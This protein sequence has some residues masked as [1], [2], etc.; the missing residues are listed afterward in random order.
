M[1]ASQEEILSRLAEL[2]RPVSESVPAPSYAASDDLAEFERDLLEVHFKP[3]LQRL[4][5]IGQKLNDIPREPVPEAGPGVL[6]ILDR[7]DVRA[8][9]LEAK[10]SK[11]TD[12]GSGRNVLELSTRLE[13]TLEDSY[14]ELAGLKSVA[15]G[16]QESR[17][18]DALKMDSAIAALDAKLEG[19][20]SISTGLQQQLESVALD[21]Q[22]INLQY[23]SLAEGVAKV[24]EQ[25][26]D[27]SMQ[28]S[29]LGETVVSLHSECE[30]MRNEMS[31]FHDKLLPQEH[32]A[33]HT[34]LEE[35]VQ[36]IRENFDELLR[37]IA[38]LGH[39]SS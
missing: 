24:R 8:T 1:Q 19:N 29:L 20:K 22:R 3:L 35:K 18:D 36:A 12:L 34:P 4:D 2:E 7:F 13:K 38:N 10:I 26:K 9:E 30:T 31:F 37:S 6:E 16:I 32:E 25:A 28:T 15:A 33:P 21:L 5:E 14:Q 39:K 27:L 17:S 23:Q 11:L